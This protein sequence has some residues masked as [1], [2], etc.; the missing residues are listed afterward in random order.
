MQEA[1]SYLVGEHDFRNFCKKD[2]NVTHH[3]RRITHAS[4][5]PLHLGLGL[6]V[7][8]AELTLIGT[9]FLWHQVRYTVTV[10]RFVG[11]GREQPTVVRDLLQVDQVRTKPLY[12]MASDRPLLLRHC[13]YD[14]KRMG[15]GA[16]AGGGHSSSRG[17]VLSDEA[18]VRSNKWLLET[19]A[20]MTDM[21][22]QHAAELLT[23]RTMRGEL[24][25]WLD[26]GRG[27]GERGGGRKYVPLLVR[28]REA[29]P[30]VRSGKKWA[31]HRELEVEME[32][33][34]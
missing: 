2:P 6:D 34:E 24:E 11:E 5:R 33:G 21:M 15:M 22:E 9:A 29:A 18:W 4:V 30:D 19:R 1:C 23:L 13:T 8:A 10:L 31:P 17:L 14:G 32:I 26:G 20:T 12:P 27:Q 16:D 3:V 7:Q 28:R 25:G